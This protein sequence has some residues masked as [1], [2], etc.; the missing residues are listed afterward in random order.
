MR[1]VIVSS[2]GSF[3]NSKTIIRDKLSWV[4][5]AEA[6]AELF[7]FNKNE[8][9]AAACG[10][11]HSLYKYAQ[12][13]AKFAKSKFIDHNSNNYKSSQQFS[14]NRFLI[15][16][17]KICPSVIY[18]V[19]NL[20]IVVC[21]LLEKNKTKTFLKVKLIFCGGESWIPEL[22]RLVKKKFPNAKIVEFYGSAELGF[23]GWGAPGK[24]FKL[25][26]GVEA[27]C[28]KDSVIWV[29]SPYIANISSPATSGDTGWFDQSGL[30]HLCGRIDRNFKFK[31]VCVEPQVIENALKIHP[32]ITRAHVF[33][34]NNQN[35][36]SNICAMILLSNNIVI[37]HQV[38]NGELKTF[39][40][41]H[42]LAS[43]IERIMI[44]KEISFP[45]SAIKIIN[46]WPLSNSGKTNYKLIEKK[47]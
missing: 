18:T 47:W 40:L 13:R 12:F 10:S 36:D 38:K 43:E 27:W 32:K 44:Q 14:I 30:L 42:D 6:E 28:D 19:P 16:I 39:N 8:I 4:L 31:G 7:N 20:L 37:S 34:R 21:K 41:S 11:N 33:K 5:S 29:K 26:P 2:S 24:G 23:V 1:K 35:K 3:G 25:F 15:N 45:I 46:T 22:D 9:F 17:K